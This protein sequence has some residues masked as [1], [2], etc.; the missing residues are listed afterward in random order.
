MKSVVLKTADHKA[1]L[2]DSDGTFRQANNRGYIAGQVLR[3]AAMPLLRRATAIGPWPPAKKSRND[4]IET[5]HMTSRPCR[6]RRTR[7]RAIRRTACLLGGRRH[8]GCHRPGC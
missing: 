3:Q 5:S 4:T 8:L 2:L 6:I 7:K 1:I